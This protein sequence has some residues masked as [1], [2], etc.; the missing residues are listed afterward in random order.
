LGGKLEVFD[1]TVKP[2]STRICLRKGEIID[3]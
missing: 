2:S 1:G 3:L